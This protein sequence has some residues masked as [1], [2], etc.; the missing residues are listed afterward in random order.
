MARGE[1][2]SRWFNTYIERLMGRRR[3]R[4]VLNHK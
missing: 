4:W 3:G 2:D 1:I